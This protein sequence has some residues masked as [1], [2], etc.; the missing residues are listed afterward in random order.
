MQLFFLWLHP[1]QVT[2]VPEKL[3]PFAVRCKNLAVSNART[4]L[5]TPEIYVSQNIYEQLLDLL[6]EGFSATR[7]F[8]KDAGDFLFTNFLLPLDFKLILLNPSFPFCFRVGRGCGVFG[9]GHCW[10]NVRPGGAYLPGGDR[11]SVRHLPGTPQRLGLVP[12]RPLLL[13]RCPPLFQ[14][15]QRYCQGQEMSCAHR[16]LQT[17]SSVLVTIIGVIA[18]HW[19]NDGRAL[20]F[21]FLIACWWNHPSF[22]FFFFLGTDGTLS[23][24]RCS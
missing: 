3:L 2:K 21:F 22:F 24:E 23:S 17:F 11:S 6:L 7:K 19:L 15:P 13:L 4:V 14:P 16:C 18:F 5:L 20:F 9:G 10:H 1:H 12:A 8:A